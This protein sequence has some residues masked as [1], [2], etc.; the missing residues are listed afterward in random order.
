[1]SDCVDYRSMT[2]QR[3][4]FQPND[5]RRTREV[6]EAFD[7]A[8]RDLMVEAVGAGWREAEAALAL[9]DAA[10]D[11]IMFLSEHPRRQMVAANSN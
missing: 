1:M 6:R 8:I 4:K 10:D 3:P 7:V 5:P 2:L 11:Y 9:A